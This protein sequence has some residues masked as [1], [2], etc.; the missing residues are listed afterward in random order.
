MKNFGIGTIY[1]SSLYI[2]VS[3]SYLIGFSNKQFLIFTHRSLEQD[4]EGLQGLSS[5]SY[6]TCEETVPEELGHF[7]SSRP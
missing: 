3:Y 5:L 7:F 1:Y 2:F 4:Q 6:F